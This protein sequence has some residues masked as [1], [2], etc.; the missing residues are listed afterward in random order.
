MKHARLRTQVVDQVDGRDPREA[1]DLWDD[2]DSGYGVED[3]EAQSDDPVCAEHGELLPCT[4][5][6][7]CQSDRALT[8][9]TWEHIA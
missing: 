4:I 1:Y 7:E 3:Y 8:L 6:D 9:D 5:T 2:R